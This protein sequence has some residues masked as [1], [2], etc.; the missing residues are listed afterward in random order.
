MSSLHWY[1][2]MRMPASSG[3]WVDHA[4]VDRRVDVEVYRTCA[5]RRHDRPV[6][7]AVRKRFGRDAGKS[8]TA[9][10]HS[11]NNA[12]LLGFGSGQARSGGAVRSTPAKL[13]EVLGLSRT[14]P[15]S[16]LD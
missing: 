5:C 15:G 12:G 4:L 10:G 13:L 1:P 11:K 7:R 8:L 2:K 9:L 16:P 14:E 6:R 3:E